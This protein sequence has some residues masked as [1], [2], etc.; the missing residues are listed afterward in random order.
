MKGFY[1]H[2]AN[3]CG[4]ACIASLGKFLGSNISIEDIRKK[5]YLDRDG[6]NLYGMIRT[7]EKFYINLK[8]YQISQDEFQSIQWKQPFIAII[9]KAEGSHFVVIKNVK[10]ARLYLWD[11]EEGHKKYTFEN[12]QRSFSGYVLL[13]DAYTPILDSKRE[14][15]IIFQEVKKKK[16]QIFGALIFSV[17]ET[18]LSLEYLTIYRD[19]VDSIYLHSGTNLSQLGFELIIINIVMIVLY[20]I[21]QGRFITVKCDLRKALKKEFIKSVQ[22]IPVENLN[23]F[24]TGNVVDRFMSIST[25]V[26]TVLDMVVTV[27]IQIITLVISTVILA[28]INR[29]LFFVILIFSTLEILLYIVARKTIT[30]N[31]RRFIDNHADVVTFLK[32]FLSNIVS[33]KTNSAIGITDKFN[34]KINNEENQQKCLKEKV[35]YIQVLENI[36]NSTLSIIILLYGV[37]LVSHNRITIGVLFM[38][39]SY[40]QMF[41]EPLKNIVSLIPDIQTLELTIYRLQDIFMCYETEKRRIKL[42]KDTGAKNLILSDVS[43]AYGYNAPIFEHMDVTIETGKKY[44]IVGKSGTGKSTLGKLIMGVQG[45]DKGAIFFNGNDVTYD[46]SQERAKNISYLSQ[47]SQLFST[48]IIDN[49]TLWD[50]SIDQQKLEQVMQICEIHDVL[51]NKNIE[52]NT[53]IQENGSDLSGGERQRIMLAR[54]LIRDVDIYIFD[55]ATGQL[56]RET[57]RRIMKKISDFLYEK[58]QIIITHHLDLIKKEDNIIFIN[59]AHNI[60]LDTHDNLLHNNEE[61]RVYFNN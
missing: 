36:L 56:D 58:T 12:F 20:K 1:Q 15:N 60:I 21:Q 59:D 22:Q 33:V 11:P 5:A 7:A 54:M 34:E 39:E 45:A 35:L 50:E 13:V 3:D 30:T 26:E 28:Q 32:E 4:V 8:A 16:V 37:Y 57:E 43:I 18:L 53:H 42:E 9:N 41:M 40:M 24:Q 47:E 49:I 31:S 29:E 17:L 51:K 55:E 10:K 2:D 52:V 46:V 6:M 23:S 48:S 61:Y 19:I 44:Y 27:I 14:K 25:V 38:F